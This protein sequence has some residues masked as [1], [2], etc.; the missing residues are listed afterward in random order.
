MLINHLFSVSLSKGPIKISILL[1]IHRG[2]CLAVLALIF[3]LL[4][5]QIGGSY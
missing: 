5:Q 4:K 1:M 3:G 2:K